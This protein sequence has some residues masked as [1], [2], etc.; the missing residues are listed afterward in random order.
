MKKF[1]IEYLEDNMIY[2]LIVQAK[3]MYDVLDSNYSI[4]NKIISITEQLSDI[5]FKKM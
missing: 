5:Y 1:K 2:E 3:D 4:V